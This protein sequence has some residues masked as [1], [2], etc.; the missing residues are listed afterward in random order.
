MFLPDEIRP[1][2]TRP[3]FYVDVAF[4]DCLS[5]LAIEERDGR[6]LHSDEG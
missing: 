3:L 4:C 2:P 1:V 6:L 5:Q